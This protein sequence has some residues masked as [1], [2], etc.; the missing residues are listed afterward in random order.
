M[1]PIM[2]MMVPIIVM[3]VMAVIVAV[4]M[5]V[6]V[7]VMMVVVSIVV[8]VWRV[9][10][11]SAN[12][13]CLT[14]EFPY[15]REM[16]VW[17]LTRRHGRGRIHRRGAPHVHTLQNGLHDAHD[18]DH[19]VAHARGVRAHQTHEKLC[20]NSFI[21]LIIIVGWTMQ[22]HVADM[23]WLFAIGVYNTAKNNAANATLNCHLILC[24][25][26]LEKQQ[27]LDLIIL[28]SFSKWCGQHGVCWGI[29]HLGIC[30]SKWHFL[31]IAVTHAAL[32]V[33]SPS[34]QHVISTNQALSLSLYCFWGLA[35]PTSESS[36]FKSPAPFSSTV[37]RLCS[38]S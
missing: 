17:A 23:I 2:I 9:A 36:S 4:V 18:H 5:M 33:Q 35:C 25:L 3:L 7:A 38:S 29:Q 21:L 32:H 24:T 6:V 10:T 26:Q 27:F 15:C 8:V 13:F 12:T 1:S 37:A 20:H 31:L 11:P 19:G 14:M 22:T 16:F 34:L 30:R 28:K